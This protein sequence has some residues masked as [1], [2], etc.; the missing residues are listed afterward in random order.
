[1]YLECLLSHAASGKAGGR[2]PQLRSPPAP[3]EQGLVGGGGRLGT[4]APTPLPHPLFGYDVSKGS[5]GGGLAQGLGGWLCW[6]VTAPIGL[7]P[8]NLLL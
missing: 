7:S 2:H 3:V 4:L 5:G 6:P 8:L 1:M